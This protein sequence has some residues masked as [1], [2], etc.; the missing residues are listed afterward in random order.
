MLT[1]KHKATN[2][3]TKLAVDSGEL[4]KEEEIRNEAKRYFSDLLR[5]DH[6]LDV[7]AQSSFLQNIP[8]LINEQMN[9]S[10]SSIPSIMEI[11]NVVFSFDGNKAPGL[12]G[13]PMFFFQ[14]FWDI[15]GKDV[16]NGV[17]EFWGA[18]RLLKEINGTFIAL[19]PKIQGADSMDKFKPISLC[20]SFYKI[21]SKVLTTRILTVLPSLINHQQNGFVLGRQIL[22]SI[23]TVHENIH[24]LVTGKKQGSSSSLIS[25]RPMTRLIGLFLSRFLWLMAFPPNVLTS[26]VNLLP[27]PLFLF[28]SMDHHPPSSKRLED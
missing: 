7:D 18:R 23:I 5:R 14:D 27:Q 21:I 4:V 9:A 20:N 8:S 3:I 24:S 13:F 11:K 12:D 15:V 17:K 19:I 6:R 10:L 2:K 16:S 25:L 28:L 26:S 1:I 22:D